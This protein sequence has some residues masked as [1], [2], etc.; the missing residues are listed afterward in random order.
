LRYQT[1]EFADL[2]IH[3]RGLRDSQEC[4]GDSY[5]EPL[6]SSSNWALFGVL[7]ESGKVLAQLMCD[8][9]IEGRRILEVGCGLGIAS[10][11]L[12]SRLAD[13]SATDYHPEAQS[14][15]DANV[16]LNGGPTI[17]FARANWL[18]EDCG[19]GKFDLVIGADLLYERGQAEL[20]SKFIDA[21]ANDA[22]EVIIVDPGRG[23]LGRLGTQMKQ[24]G[25]T[26]RPHTND[27]SIAGG[28][29]V[30]IRHYCRHSR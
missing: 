18:D 11:V 30:Q 3:V 9:D 26:D 10:L 15:L 8:F 6:L 22:C 4:G 29:R 2:D 14:F 5:D 25:Y 19:L 20:L 21:H 23:Q 13:I 28:P 1:V 16:A 7:W 17:P 12:N 24:L 27:D